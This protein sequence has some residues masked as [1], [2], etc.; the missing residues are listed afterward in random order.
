[1]KNFKNI[2]LKRVNFIL[3][4]F[5][6]ITLLLLQ[7]ISALTAESDSYST[8]RFDSGL[9]A[10][11]P[12]SET[13]Q[14][15]AILVANAGTP[16]GKNDQLIVNI[17]FFENVVYRSTVSIN[18]YSISPK[19]AV[20]GSTIGLYI[21]ASNVQNVWAKITSPNNQE[22]T[23]TLT[24]NQFVNYLP[25]P[26]A[27]GR[28]NIVFYANS[29]SG[30]IASI[31]DYFDLTEQTT[32]SQPTNEGASGGSSKETNNKET[33][34][35]IEKCTYVWDCT[36]WSLCSEGKQIRECK[37]I[38]T[39]AGKENK[40]N[41]EIKCSEKLFDI[42]IG[43]K[44]L[45]LTQ[46]DT[47][48]FDIELVEKIDL[49]KIDVHIKYSIVNSSNSEI[50]SQIE[51]K[52]VKENLTY[53]KEIRGIELKDGDY[54]L[55]VDILYG[56]LQRA[57]SEQKFKIRDKKISQP[58]ITGGVI[59]DIPYYNGK[60]I[61]I[62]L[63]IFI[64]ILL[65]MLRKKLVLIRNKV[66]QFLSKKGRYQKNRVLGLINKKVYSE[67][68]NYIGKLKEVI[69]GENKIANLKI[70]IKKKNK[71]KTNGIIINYKHVKN[72]SEIIII[73]EIVSEH[74]DRFTEK[75]PKQL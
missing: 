23:L 30:T 3:I 16:N 62:L 27:L 57:F 35:I 37:N 28:Y 40:P 53:E 58:D 43:L 49:E 52:A 73:D 42:L 39:C 72:I 36:P 31:V 68:G 48:K 11:N 22:Q 71:L 75:T 9:Q 46:S 17:G 69:L 61:L 50:F 41:E 74:L 13:H 10:S 51:T 65:V 38:G 24:N 1:M 59:N 56:N 34:K 14:S 32:P 4:I 63:I 25:S 15:S 29:S 60:I 20:I 47:L 66:I 45:E 5:L 55:R 64:I 2:T 67:S 12:S 18:S 33:T 19:S 70:K 8:R 26:S 44:K 6:L 54:T 21:S 7:K